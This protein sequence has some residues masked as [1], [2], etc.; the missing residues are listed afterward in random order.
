MTDT[1]EAPA[2]SAPRT[3]LERKRASRERTGRVYDRA[4]GDAER[5]VVAIMHDKYPEQYAHMA[6]A[7]AARAPASDRAIRQSRTRSACCTWFRARHRAEWDL[8]LAR[9]IAEQTA[10]AE[11]VSE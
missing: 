3:A 7:A 9:H 11:P 10:A 8:I 1:V 6:A 5:E 2:P 4:R